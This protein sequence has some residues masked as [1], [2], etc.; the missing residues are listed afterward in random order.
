MNTVRTIVGLS[1]AFLLTQ[2]AHS[3]TFFGLLHEPVGGTTLTGTPLGLRVSDISPGAPAGVSVLMPADSA[4]SRDLVGTMLGSPASGS[5][6]TLRFVSWGRTAGGGEVPVGSMIFDY[7][8]SAPVCSI[9][10]SALGTVTL[11]ARYYSGGV[12]VH[13]ESGINALNASFGL[14]PH[15][16]LQDLGWS[17]H[18]VKVGQFYHL[19]FDG[20][21]STERSIGGS[22]IPRSDSWIISADGGTML[23]EDLTRVDVLAT[24]LTEFTITSMSYVPTPGALALLGLGGVCIARRRR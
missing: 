5:G 7:S 20:T 15:D 8:G 11:S 17:A 14:L 16:T 3:Q 1:A 22:D 4:A 6:T 18:W 24:G 10:F 12:L 23:L 19:K 2:H 21:H 13:E 9:D